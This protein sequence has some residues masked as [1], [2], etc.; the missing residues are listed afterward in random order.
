MR[1][2]FFF[3]LLS[4]RTRRVSRFVLPVRSTGKPSMNVEQSALLGVLA[5]CCCEVKKE[6]EKL[7]AC[8]PAGRGLGCPLTST[9]TNAGRGN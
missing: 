2:F 5:D 8:V 1:I 4:R 6:K 7:V 9:V 3:V